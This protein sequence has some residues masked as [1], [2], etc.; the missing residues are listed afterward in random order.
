MR[1]CHAQAMKMIKEY[2][3]QKRLLLRRE[4]ENFRVSY[5]EGEQKIA[6]DYDYAAVRAEITR[7]DAEVR[8]IRSALAKANCSVKI[9]GFDL[10][11]GE[12]LVYLAQ[13]CNERQHL[14][15]MAD[16]NQLSR[17]LTTNGVIE[18]TEC[19]FDVAKVKKDAGDLRQKISE[20]QI[21]I[22]RANLVNFIEF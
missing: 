13:L 4:A 3:E 22:D 10:T 15:G 7:L 12:A 8:K 14:D 11:I 5:K 20:L 16:N 6:T 17:R 1:V 19:L 9:D 2:E 21:A 18:Y